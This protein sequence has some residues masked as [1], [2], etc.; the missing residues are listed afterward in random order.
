MARVKQNVD[1]DEAIELVFYVHRELVGEPDRLLARRGLGRVHHRILYCISRAPGITVG[2]VCRAL[3]ITKQALH[4][5]L[6]TLIRERLVARSTDEA[7]R[8]I[9]RLQLTN[10]GVTLEQ[11]PLS[12]A[13]RAYLQRHPASPDAT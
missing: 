11:H 3:G 13:E 7:N 2:G 9:R 4:Q 10:A 5:P 6:A 8:R 12:R 1:Y